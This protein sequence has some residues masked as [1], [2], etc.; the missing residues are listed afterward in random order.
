MNL[1]ELYNAFKTL[2]FKEVL[3]F[4]RIWIQTLLPSVITIALYFIIFGQLIGSQLDDIKGYKYIDYIVPGMIMMSII[5]N[6]YSN[7]VAS[8]YSTKFQKH[9]EE[10]L[11][12]PMPNYVII[13]GFVGGGIARSM[14][15]GLAVTATASIF[16]EIRFESPMLLLTVALLTS[17]L[18]S[19]AGLVNAVFA[20]SF[21]DI[22]L[23]PTFV[24][25]PL[26]YLG[27]IFYSID[28]L[29]DLWRSLSHLNPV[30]YMV[31]AFRLAMLGVSDMNMRLSL[32]I[33]L[34]FVVILYAATDMLL[35][36]G[37]GIR[38]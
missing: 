27:G 35:R 9:I 15:V 33:I 5:T 30:L 10:M 38:S 8:F 37:I 34:G 36:K 22:S 24:L 14:L 32:A 1:I 16:T 12:S 17:I 6:A 19:L 31:D 20:N 29:P 2:L 21:D 18:F 28:M 13:W 25:T 4:L 7:V 23:V 11:V 26:T 3:R